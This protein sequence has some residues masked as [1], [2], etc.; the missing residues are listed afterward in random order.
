MPSI[1]FSRYLLKLCELLSP[2]LDMI[3]STGSRGI[4]GERVVGQTS[5][6]SFDHVSFRR[7]SY[8]FLPFYLSATRHYL[9]TNPPSHT[10]C[11]FICFWLHISS[12]LIPFV[13]SI[14]EDIKSDM[15]R[16]DDH[17]SPLLSS[18]LSIGYFN[19]PYFGG[20]NRHLQTPTRPA[21]FCFHYRFY[22][23][24]DPAMLH[25]RASE[26][27]EGVSRHSIRNIFHGLLSLL[28]ADTLLISIHVDPHPVPAPEFI[29]SLL[30]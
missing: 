24:N 13:P 22:K 12:Y 18:P 20:G 14:L 3:S 4:L 5:Y 6:V 26:S 10:E 19:S 17:V 27:I 21:P 2:T 30:R 8:S 25:V 23:P 28:S 11:G 16:R 9:H 7:F 1:I 15:K 29:V